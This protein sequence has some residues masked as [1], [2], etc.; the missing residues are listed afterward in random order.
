VKPCPE[1]T[2]LHIFIVPFHDLPTLSACALWCYRWMVSMSLGMAFFGNLPRSPWN[3]TYSLFPFTIFRLVW[4]CLLMQPIKGK[5]E[6]R[7][8]FLQRS[9]P[10]RLPQVAPCLGR[11]ETRFYALVPDS[12]PMKAMRTLQITIWT[13]VTGLA[14]IKIIPAVCGKSEPGNHYYDVS[15]TT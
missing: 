6:S 3:C 11:H 12:R 5:Y 1:S 9:I 2:K 10:V 8:G 13:Y 14:K 15:P 7:H 4:L